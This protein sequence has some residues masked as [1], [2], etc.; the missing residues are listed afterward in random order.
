MVLHSAVS[1][2]VTGL[3][4]RFRKP[5]VLV[6]AVMV[7]LVLG[8]LYGYSIFWQPLEGE[9]WPP[10]LTTDQ[11]ALLTASGEPLPRDA[12]IVAT[13]AAAVLEREHRLGLLKYCFGICLLSFAA[14][15]VVAGRI[16]DRKGPRVT[17][18]VGGLC[19][20]LAFLAAGRMGTLTVY[21]LCHAV[22][23][24][25]VV[26]AVLVLS[27]ALTRG[28]DRSRRPILQ[29]LPYGLVTVAVIGG[30]ALG[31]QYISISPVNKMFLLW[32]TVGVLAG[33]GT[34]FAYVSPIAALV[35]WFPRH[36]GLVSGVAVA[37][38]GLGAYIFSGA[39]Q[40]GG[41]GFIEAHGIPDFFSLHGIIATLVVCAGAFL[42]CNPPAPAVAS[43][44]AAEPRQ[45]DS[46]WRN[47]L[48]NWRF[49]QVWIMFFSGAMAGLMVIGILKPFAGSQLV[50]SAEAAG[51]T[52][53]DSLRNELLL[54]GATAVGVLAIFNAAGRVAWG[55]VSDRIGRSLSMTVMFFLQ[56]L[57]LLTFTTLDTEL[58]LAIGAAC[59]GFNFGG[60]FALFPSL[61]ADLFGSKGFGANYGWV[62]TSYGVA[63]VLGVWAGNTARQ[64]TGSFTAAFA[65]AAVLCMG[66]AALSHFSRH[67]RP[68]DEA[69]SSA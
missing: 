23:M 7:Q 6:G 2:G 39:S 8:T 64:L 22:L 35:K 20:G 37:G 49:Y 48:K 30:L 47:L 55:W 28:M 45:A 33:V 32:S 50:H 44:P 13:A 62:F 51:K 27:D 38:F 31:Q 16:Q 4:A 14:S 29:Y 10:I 42:L 3:A 26:V 61:T 34:G 60:N 63:G 18:V 5:L 1:E 66:S 21:Y 54:R 59:V 69:M 52:L 15:M 43:R 12:A 11:A 53:S 46:S 65:V 56:G 19:L 9:I 17:A 67:W 40:I 24:G 41:V 57:T 68:A 25:G 36:K 58:E